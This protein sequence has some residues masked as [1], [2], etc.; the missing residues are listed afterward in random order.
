MSI[1]VAC[2]SCGKMLKAPDRLAGK[3]AKC[4]QCGAVVQ[5]KTVPVRPNAVP[6]T[7]AS[8]A[9]SKPK[10]SSGVESQRVKPTRRIAVP[11][12]EPEPPLAEL[13]EDPEPVVEAELAEPEKPEEATPPA[14]GAPQ[15]PRTKKRKKKRRPAEASG[16]GVPRWVW[17]AG[18]T[19]ILV[20]GT[21]IGVVL[22]IQAGH[23]EVVALCGIELAIMVP[24]STVILIVSMILSSLLAGGIDFGE[25]HIVIP[26]AIF[27]LLVINLVMLVPFGAFLVFPI[28]LV[29]LLMLFSLDLWECRFLIAINW[30]LNLIVKALL[31]GLMLHALTHVH[32]GKDTDE[33]PVHEPAIPAEQR[34]AP[35][36]NDAP[37]V[38]DEV[39]AGGQAWRVAQACLRSAQPRCVDLAAEPRSRR[40]SFLPW[41]CQRGIAAVLNASRTGPSSSDAALS[42]A[43]RAAAW[44]SLT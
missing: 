32:P 33:E 3:K 10:P 7:V 19:V 21:A 8:P 1:I 31:L 13:W 4:S 42:V 6:R 14:A 25:V 43:L 27:L 9:P 36:G 35:D 15:R 12:P 24:I 28:W 5:V 30:I 16:A 38:G 41:D 20:L 39:N 2:R 34:D 26:K 40:T 18:A 44:S 29:G 17:W 37:P 11:P 22:A 23:G